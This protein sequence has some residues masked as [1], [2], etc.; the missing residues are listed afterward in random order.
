MSEIHGRDLDLNLLRVFAVVAESGGVTEAA[1]RLYLTQSAISAALRRLTTAVGAPLFVRNGRGI[2]LTSRGE[3]LRASVDAHL[4][5]LVEGALAPATFDPKTTERTL[6]VGLSDSA[7]LWALPPLLRTLER[8]APRLRI[9]AIPVQFRTVAAA[10]AA[11]LAA[12][13]TVADELPATIRRERLFYG[14]FTC[15]YDPRH[16]RLPRTLTEAAYFAHDH[17]IV[18]YNGDLRGIVEDMFDKARKVR[19]SVSGF[20]NIG[21]IVDGTAMLATIPE[22]VAAKI[23]ATRPHLR[24][25]PL[26]SSLPIEGAHAELLW[27][28]VT[29]DDEPCKF[30]RTKIRQIVRTAGMGK[31]VPIR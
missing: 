12:A 11:G 7:E 19:C 27:P 5:P 14:G 8:E 17:V 24:T 9:V 31:P 3:R 25:K 6:R 26:P 23:R 30:L 18:S 20:A 2:A 15:L 4:G 16:A 22:M 28:S 29:D 1:R 10:L 21:A 13:I